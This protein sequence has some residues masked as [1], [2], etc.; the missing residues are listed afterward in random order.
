MLNF[1]SSEPLTSWTLNNQP[2]ISA[3]TEA[4]TTEVANP[5]ELAKQVNE[6]AAGSHD[7]GIMHL[8]LNEGDA[9]LK[10]T[11]L[12]LVLMS[13]YSWTV[14]IYRA[15]MIYVVSA[16]SKQHLKILNS[17]AY[18]SYEVAYQAM[19]GNSPIKELVGAALNSEQQYT[20]AQGALSQAID[21]AEY[22]QRNIR[23]GLEKTTNSQDGGLS[24]LATIGATAPFIGLFGTVWGIYRAL[25]SI[26][27]TGNANIATIAGPIGEVLVATAFGLFVA[28]PAV[29]C[30]NVFIRRNR[31]Y[32]RS[33]DGF[34]HDLYNSFLMQSKK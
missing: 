11:F 34:A 3:A 19:Q 31:V 33:L 12:I 18:P 1:S 2:E 10:L 20:Q 8:I 9:I 32:A 22:L 28:I 21:Y 14:I 5:A 24:V 25:L 30:Y 17:S 13:L 16:K 29:L 26:S 27:A 6:L 4:T 23:Y 7:L 15:I